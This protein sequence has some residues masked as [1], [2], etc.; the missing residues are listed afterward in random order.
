[1]SN[2]L[3]AL[4]GKEACPG[5]LTWSAFG[6]T[7]PDTV[8]ANSLTWPDGYH[9]SGL[10]DA[11][12][13]FLEGSVPCPFCQSLEFLI[14]LFGED[15]ETQMLW[16]ADESPVPADTEIHFHDGVALWWTATH[17]VRGEERVLMRSL[18]DADPHE[19]KLEA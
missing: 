16:A 6:A 13:D 4:P 14:Y 7:Y 17:P 15:G 10:C 18:L 5:N 9:G 8:C 11:D 19:E 3:A 2:V 1:M 12:N